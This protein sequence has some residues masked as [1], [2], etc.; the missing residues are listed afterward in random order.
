VRVSNLFGLF[1]FAEWQ[2]RV[3]A[4]ARR[5]K[6]LADGSENFAR[7]PAASGLRSRG[8]YFG[9]VACCGG[10]SSVAM[11]V[12]VRDIPVLPHGMHGLALTKGKL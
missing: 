9:R 11:P 7:Y 10:A 5:P 6:A 8:G 1:S 12:A 2:R 4:S 3:V